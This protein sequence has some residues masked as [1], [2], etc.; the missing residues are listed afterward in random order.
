MRN[1]CGVWI[2]CP[3][4]RGSD[5]LGWRSNAI[6]REGTPQQTENEQ[7]PQP[8]HPGA[9]ENAPDLFME[10]RRNGTLDEYLKEKGIEANELYQQ[11]VAEQ[12]K[13]PDG[14]PRGPQTQLL[15]EEVV[16]AQMLDF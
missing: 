8:L 12:P 6:L 5:G 13:G 7:F 14:H 15:A 4:H 9:P 11:L 3:T 2:A 10:L 16:M 1:S